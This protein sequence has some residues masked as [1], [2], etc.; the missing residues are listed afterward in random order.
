MNAWLVGQ[1]SFRGSASGNMMKPSCLLYLLL[2]SHFNQ[3]QASFRAYDCSL[4]ESTSFKEISLK[5]IQTCKDLKQ[6]YEEPHES[7]IQVIKRNSKRHLEAFNCL[8]KLSISAKPC[9]NDAIYNYLYAGFDIIN[10]KIV[11]IDHINCLKSF[12]TG[13]LQV[14]SDGISFE[15]QMKEKVKASGTIYLKGGSDHLG[16]CVGQAFIYKEKAYRSSVLTAEYEILV[17]KNPAIYDFDSRAII[18]PGKF[19]TKTQNNYIFDQAF[20]IFVWNL[21]DLPKTECN[22]YQEILSGNASSYNPIDMSSHHQRITILEDKKER[23]QA[24]LL[25]GDKTTICS[26]PVFLTQLEDIYLL[27]LREKELPLQLT[28]IQSLNTDRFTD[29]QG[30]LGIIHLS[31]E[32]RLSDAFSK[33]SKQICEANRARLESAI[34]TFSGT[35]GDLGASLEGSLSIQAGSMA[36]LFSCAP[37]FV[38]LR[39][40][41]GFCTQEI[42]VTYSISGAHIDYYANP[43]SLVLQQNSTKIPC[44]SVA[45]VK[46]AL[47][48]EKGF[49]WVCSSP[50]IT[51]CSPP[52]ELDPLVSKQSLYKTS[53][54]ELNLNLF[55]RQ[56][57]KELSKFQQHLT[58]RSAVG[59]VISDIVN[60]DE[61]AGDPA[62][63]IL[64]SMGEAGQNQIKE[65]LIPGFVL[66]LHSIWHWLYIM[67]ITSF[68]S[69]LLINLVL[70][71][72][73]IKKMVAAKG[74]GCHL[75]NCIIT[76]LFIA[77]FPFDNH[78]SCPCQQENMDL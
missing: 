55:S 58:I 52:L 20:G 46:Y 76:E 67:L 37:V 70:L 62:H 42:P 74:I 51:R 35:G 7:K 13:K 34:K 39:T 61:T 73:R 43:I 45:P 78:R 30:Q 41:Q 32:L 6:S 66:F 53:T 12:S 48:T 22:L 59:A 25:L 3:I 18:F 69:H 44:S 19:S 8:V 16:N 11:Q 71:C 60:N 10:N 17:G 4:K 21:E 72:I 40:S 14:D 49:D 31:Q 47:P 1:I 65:R 68:A 57:M 29:I 9:G 33:I 24:A 36:Y 28:E 63:A 38:E 23:R 77:T 56:Q 5:G 26:R 54:M 75:L 50:A 27:E 15:V 64:N 2:I